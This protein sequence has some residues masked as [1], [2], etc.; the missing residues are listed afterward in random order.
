MRDNSWLSGEVAEWLKA[1]DCKSA[2]FILRWFESSPLHHFCSFCSVV[3]R[4]SLQLCGCSTLAV[5][6]VKVGFRNAQRFATVTGIAVFA[7]HC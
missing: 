7:M 1:A 5:Q 2:G 4:C 6:K 3:S